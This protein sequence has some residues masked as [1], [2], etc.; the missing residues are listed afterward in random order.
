MT[1]QGIVQ[2]EVFD[3]VVVG[4]GAGGMATAITAAR[5]GLSVV[6][7][8]KSEYWGGSFARSGGGCGCRGTPCYAVTRRPTTSTRPAPT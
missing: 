4:S 3:L 5:R 6:I 2:G 8:E 7:V 1:Q